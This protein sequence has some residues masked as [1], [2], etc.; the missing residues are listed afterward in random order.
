MK[1]RD[2]RFA[3]YTPAQ[4]IAEWKAAP[5]GFRAE[6]VLGLLEQAAKA[7]QREISIDNAQAE[8]V[9]TMRAVAEASGSPVAEGAVA[10]AGIGLEA[11]RLSA[12]PSLAFALAIELLRAI[13]RADD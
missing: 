3:D 6:V 10:G 9:S 4:L 11:S 7:E 1:W 12:K 2:P 8:M 5:E 13:G